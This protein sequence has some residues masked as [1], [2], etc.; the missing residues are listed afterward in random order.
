MI[1][2]ESHS[3]PVTSHISIIDK[4]KFVNI[5]GY[6]EKFSFKELHLFVVSIILL[7]IV[8][9]FLVLVWYIIILSPLVSGIQEF[10]K[11]D[12]LSKRL[13]FSF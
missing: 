4:S 1:S 5:L 13:I 6:A 3:L 11:F 10:N 8:F 2:I 9:N 12:K 7:N